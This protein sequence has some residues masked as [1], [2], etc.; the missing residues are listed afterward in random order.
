MQ[1][2]V[3]QSQVLLLPHISYGYLGVSGSVTQVRSYLLPDTGKFAL[4]F[5]YFVLKALKNFT[6]EKQQS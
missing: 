1:E 2:T 4:F 3:K 5:F 6:V